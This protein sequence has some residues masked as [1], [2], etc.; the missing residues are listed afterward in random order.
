MVRLCR[1][2]LVR[3]LGTS[4]R[5]L[6]LG[7]V[8]C[9]RTWSLVRTWV[10]RVVVVFPNRPQVTRCRTRI[11]CRVLLLSASSLLRL[12]LNLLLLLLAPCGVLRG[13]REV[14]PTLKRAVVISKKL[15]VMLRLSVLTCLVLVRHRLVILST[16]TVLTLIPRWAISRSSRL[17]GLSQIR[18]DM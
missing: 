7:L 16:E 13:I 4:F 15:S 17:N 14:V 11:L 6:G 12:L 1:A 18:A 2:T 3:Q 8:I 5:N 9:G 10:L